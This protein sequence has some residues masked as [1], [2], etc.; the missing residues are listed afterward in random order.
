MYFI[1]FAK[2]T[3]FFKNLSPYSFPLLSSF[4]ASPPPLPL[5][6]INLLNTYYVTW[7]ILSA[8]DTMTNER[9]KMPVPV[10]ICS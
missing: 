4:P 1:Y 10:R 7:S 3:I 5:F 9:N 8:G 6:S 2:Y